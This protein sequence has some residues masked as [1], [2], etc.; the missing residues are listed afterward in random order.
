MDKIYTQLIHKNFRKFIE[1][2]LF[3]IIRYFYNFLVEVTYTVV[4]FFILLTLEVT[5]QNRYYLSSNTLNILN[6]HWSSWFHTSMETE[7]TNR[8]TLMSRSCNCILRCAGK[9]CPCLPEKFLLHLRVLGALRGRKNRLTAKETK[10]EY[11]FFLDITLCLSSC[12][13]R[14]SRLNRKKVPTQHK[15]TPVRNPFPPQAFPP[16]ALRTA[17]CVLGCTHVHPWHFF[18]SGLAVQVLN[19]PVSPWHHGRF[20]TLQD[21]QTPGKQSLILLQTWGVGVKPLSWQPTR[22]SGW[23]IFAGAMMLNLSGTP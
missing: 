4:C 11:M 3:I 22:R 9:P 16:C 19:K 8:I 21:L 18:I 10:E 12:P 7:F 15:E 17:Y 2:T 6:T 20:H 5:H 23:T 14:S 1:V 13:W